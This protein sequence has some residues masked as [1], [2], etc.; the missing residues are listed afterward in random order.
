MK[1]NQQRLPML[2][3]G[4]DSMKIN[5]ND[6]IKER[7]R[8]IAMEYLKMEEKQTTLCNNLA[9]KIYRKFDETNKSEKLCEP[10][11]LAK[12][13]HSIIELEKV[14][15][16]LHLQVVSEIKERIDLW[17]QMPYFGDIL[18]KYFKF[19]NV[20]KQILLHFPKSQDTLVELMK[21]QKFKEFLQKLL[22]GN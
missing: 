5:E 20:Y 3:K 19:Y 1:I 17:N 11:D 15:Q 7:R 4:E 13:F 12:I 2:I 6:E 8:N 14:A 9:T 10:D 16:L 18:K 21:K 22:V